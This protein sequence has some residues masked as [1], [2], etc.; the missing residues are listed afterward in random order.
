MAHSLQPPVDAAVRCREARYSAMGPHSLLA[1]AGHGCFGH[2]CPAHSAA[3][4]AYAAVRAA[5]A[6]RRS[7]VRWAAMILAAL[8]LAEER[9][10]QKTVQAELAWAEPAQHMQQEAEA[11]HM[12]VGVAAPQVWQRAGDR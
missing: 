6:Q 2:D 12:L 4:A 3:M 9:C 7:A 5:A 11:E 1:G 10:F 8:P